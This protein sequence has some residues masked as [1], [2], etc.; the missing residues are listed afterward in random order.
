[1]SMPVR[2]EFFGAARPASTLVEVTRLVRPDLLVEIE[3]V[4]GLPK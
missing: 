1:M 4:A 3:A 2:R